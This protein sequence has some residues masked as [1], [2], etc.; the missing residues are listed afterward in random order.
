MVV[1]GPPGP[2]GLRNRK[3]LRFVQPCSDQDSRNGVGHHPD[4]YHY[5]INHAAKASNEPHCEPLA[6]E[7]LDALLRAG[8][9]SG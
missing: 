1:T 5:E 7:E 3:V 6:E 9:T 4:T 8:T 2:L